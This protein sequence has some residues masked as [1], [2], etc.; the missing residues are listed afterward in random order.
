VYFLADKFSLYQGD[1]NSKKF[2][3]FDISD[4]SIYRLN[5]VAYDM[6]ELFDGEKKLS[7]I[8]DILMAVY[9]VETLKLK[10]DLNFMVQNWVSNN[11][12]IEK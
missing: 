12:L 4:G 9:E 3:L 11:I 6:L 10:E 8:Y 7:D 2:F 5:E 1:F